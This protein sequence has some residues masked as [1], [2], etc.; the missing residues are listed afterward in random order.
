MGSNLDSMHV[1]GDKPSGDPYAL[2]DAERQAII[3]KARR[4]MP[5]RDRRFAEATAEIR[6]LNAVLFGRRSR[7]SRS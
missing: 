4:E 1:E 7:A 5:E 2:T 6:R 3:E